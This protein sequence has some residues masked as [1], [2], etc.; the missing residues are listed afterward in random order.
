MTDL[1]GKLNALIT[2][3]LPGL[4]GMTVVEATPERVVGTMLVRA[5]MC[6]AGGILHGGAYMAFA[7]TLGALST[8]INMPTGANTATIESKTNFIGGAKVGST[9]IGTTRAF[10][11]GKTTHVWQTEITGEDGKLLAVVSQTQIIMPPKS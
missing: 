8:V 7:D 6:T 9:V 4:L 1:A 11:K 2:P 10:H 3:M 5:D